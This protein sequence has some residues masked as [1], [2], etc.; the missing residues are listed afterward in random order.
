MQKRRQYDFFSAQGI[1]CTK[2][3]VRS[4]T[5][6]NGRIPVILK[7]LLI[8]GLTMGRNLMDGAELKE[9]K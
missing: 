1:R 8:G 4:I 5:F 9:R 7:G 6:K 3:G 2:F